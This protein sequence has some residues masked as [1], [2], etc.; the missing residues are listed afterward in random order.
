[1]LALRC[2]SE[3]STRWW[4]SKRPT[5]QTGEIF[6]TFG[7]VLGEHTKKHFLPLPRWLQAEEIMTN[8][9]W[10]T[11]NLFAVLFLQ[12]FLSPNGRR[13]LFLSNGRRLFT[14][15]MSFCCVPPGPWRLPKIKRSI[16]SIFYE[17]FLVGLFRSPFT[18]ESSEGIFLLVCVSSA[19]WLSN[20]RSFLARGTL[21]NLKHLMSTTSLIIRSTALEGRKWAGI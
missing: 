10:L 7:A 13:S 3:C 2:W 8:F 14:H 12:F 5:W 4:G 9:I 20:E 16:L 18:E 15:L 11:C 1:M 6:T 17:I 21:K 19:K